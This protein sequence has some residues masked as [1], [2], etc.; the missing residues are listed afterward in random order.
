MKLT[1]LHMLLTYK[2]IYECDHCFVWGSPRQTG[3]M[4]L[5]TIDLALQQAVE[6]G[7]V[8]WV[9][10]EGGEPFLYYPVLQAAVEAAANR[11]FKVGIVTN[12]YWAIDEA[13]A[14][15]W[16]RPF[17]GKLEDLSISGDLYHGNEIIGE[18]VAHAVKAAGKLGIPTNVITIGQP[19]EGKP[20]PS[21]A[22]TSQGSYRVIYRGRA[23]SELAGQADKRA[24]DEFTACDGEDLREPGRLHLDP[25]GEL[26]VCQGISIGNI[27][28]T[29]L[30]QICASYDPD[31]HPVVGPLLE[32]GPVRLVGR[33]GLAHDDEY[34]DACHL[35]YEARRSLRDRL[36]ETL[37][38]D[39]MYGDPGKD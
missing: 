11:G 34:A 3:T 17:E 4:T 28:R 25:F 27:Q 20:E 31:A 32:G 14:E 6:V 13:D 23:A 30:K 9:Y 22:P 36:P 15:T 5:R 10:F 37:T 1:G 24:W 29:P 33:Y 8:E 16:L 19:G 35:C 39:P 7:T 2:C 12:A 21:G 26:H 18:N 38:P